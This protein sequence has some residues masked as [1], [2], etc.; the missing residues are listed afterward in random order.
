MATSILIYVHFL[1][2]LALS[3]YVLKR[4]EGLPSV[5]L[6]WIFVFFIIPVAGVLLYSM[7]GY[8]DMRRRKRAKP[9]PSKKLSLL[10]SATV[11]PA[12]ALPDDVA[13]VAHLCERLTEF[14]VV[15]GNQ[16]EIFEEAFATYEALLRDIQ[17][18]R[19][20]VHLE[21]YL[22]QPDDA[23]R[24]FRDLL[25]AKAKSGVECRLLVDHIGS[26]KLRKEFLA[27]LAEAGVRFAFFWPVRIL[28]PWS[29][30][31]RN[32]RKIAVVDGE[33]GY[34]GSQNIG[35][36]Y[37]NFKNRR[38]SW[39]DTQV[40]I[41]GPA[42]QQLQT[43]FA[44]DWEFTTQESLVREPYFRNLSPSGATLVQ[45]LPTGPDEF[46][47]AFESILLT[48]AHLARDRMTLVTPYLV[49]TQTMAIALAAAVKRGV[50][51]EILV[52]RK[53]DNW[54]VDRISRSWYKD[55][56]NLGARV[57]Q[58]RRTFLH[59]KV[60]TVDDKLILIGS[61]NMDERSFRLNFENSLLIYDQIATTRLVNS[62]DAMR[63]EAEE[64]YA[65]VLNHQSTLR[66][67][68]DGIFRVLSPLF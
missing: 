24:R 20:H 13:Q 32:H 12:T 41:K 23:G 15:G 54:L 5:T 63:S 14:P 47:F 55:L 49:P 59:A 27:P 38:L 53:S 25:I 19:H 43:I 1:G 36:E 28:R 58:Y 50:K 35:N 4:R 16:V 68:L 8:R 37:A 42:V 48:L 57:F 22:F 2:A 60:I 67:V 17:A 40:R 29:F 64:I 6:S 65:D 3:L 11:H 26:F 33:I 52:P 61:A 18:A 62:Y 45:T 31:L 30:H 44:E 51:V 34:T 21:Y 9:A 46:D 7:I 39:R 10:S 56:L 66:D